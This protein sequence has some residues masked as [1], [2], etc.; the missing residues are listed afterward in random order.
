MTLLKAEPSIDEIKSALQTLNTI[1]LQA[2]T[3]GTQIKRSKGR[4]FNQKGIEA[5]GEVIEIGRIARIAQ[6]Y[7]EG[8]SPSS[9]NFVSLAPAGKG[10]FKVWP[11]S[12]EEDLFDSQHL[13]TAAFSGQSPTLLPVV[14]YENQDI[15]LEKKVEKTWEDELKAGGSVGAVIVV[16]GLIAFFFALWR[17]I[18]LL[19]LGRSFNDKRVQHVF[20]TLQSKEKVKNLGISTFKTWH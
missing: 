8:S 6:L 20:K 10:H 7:K 9:L 3:E 2:L 19:I 11:L 4:F 14:L 1:S 17:M 13:L 16:L 5:E 12:K 18:N 15:S